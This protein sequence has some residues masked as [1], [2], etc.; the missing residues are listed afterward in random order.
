M[1]DL[2]QKPWFEKHRPRT[3]EDVVFESEQLERQLKGFVNQGFIEGNIISYGPGGV[4]KTTLNK[5]LVTSIVKTEADF[6][7][8]GKSVTDIEK[9]KVWLLDKPLASRQR[10]V[11]CEEFDQLS[12]QA[13]TALKN[14]LMENYMPDVS[15]I[16]TTNNIHNIDAALLQR[17]NVKLNFSTYNI[18]GVYF[19][20]IKILELEQVQFDNDELYKLTIAFEKKGI[21]EL[22]NNIQAGTIDKIFKIENLPKNLISTS[23]IEDSIVGYIKYY[24]Q[25]I[26]TLAPDD[27]YNICLKP[28][29]DT[30]LNQY[31]T[32]MLKFMEN[33][34]SINYEHI[35]KTL[36][37]DPDVLLPL[38]HIITDYYQK[39]K[40]VPLQ[41]IQ[42]QSCLFEI[43][44]ELYT[45]RGGEKR[46][47]H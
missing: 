37:D 23:G 6:F 40:L 7:K 30:T 35:Y 42:L 38:K 1:V 15:Y 25:Y 16:V 29:S 32:P 28:Q 27:I 33:D 21:R 9:L 2:M 3:M 11:V 13:Q 4:G 36:L 41:N 45:L 22:I 46:L 26:M 14:G 43:F 8:L 39:L 12:A 31:Y 19:R 18:D 24:I 5:I 44:I 47:I 10:I 20:M 34:P 17:F